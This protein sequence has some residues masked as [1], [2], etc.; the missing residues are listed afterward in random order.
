MSLGTP[1]LAQVYGQMVVPTA[2]LPRSSLA[3]VWPGVYLRPGSAP[4]IEAWTSGPRRAGK[5]GGRGDGNPQ[6]H[7]SRHPLW[8]LRQSSGATLA[9]RLRRALPGVRT[10]P[11]DGRRAAPSGRG[12]RAERGGQVRSAR[13]PRGESSVRERSPAPRDPGAGS[14][15]PQSHASQCSTLFAD[16]L[17][18]SHRGHPAAQR[19]DAHG[20]G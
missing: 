17:M 5:S 10:H 9:S 12:R 15:C 18:R 4:R 6:V 19:P 20:A 2:P 14:R 11:V 7:H 8:R 1:W 3:R 16:A 13:R